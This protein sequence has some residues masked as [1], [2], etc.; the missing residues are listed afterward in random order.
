[1]QHR[2]PRGECDP[3]RLFGW[4]QRHSTVD[5]HFLP[6]GGRSGDDP[7]QQLLQTF[8][9]PTSADW[10]SIPPENSQAGRL[11]VATSIR[12]QEQLEA[13]GIR[14]SAKQH[15][16]KPPM[17]FCVDRGGIAGSRSASVD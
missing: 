1:M 8:G 12:V 9:G 15:D 16:E 6:Y 2:H 4:I 13:Q 3:E 14:L 7:F 10:R 11:A 17:H 5:V